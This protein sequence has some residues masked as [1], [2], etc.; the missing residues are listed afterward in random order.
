M[1]KVRVESMW[2]SRLAFY[3]N[4]EIKTGA[5][6]GNSDCPADLSLY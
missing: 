3:Y 5:D 2:D 1:P 4:V 6:H